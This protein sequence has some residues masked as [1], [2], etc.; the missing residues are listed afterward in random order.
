MRAC[1]LFAPITAVVFSALVGCDDSGLTAPGLGFMVIQTVTNGSALDPDGYM[2]VVSGEAASDTSRVGVIERLDAKNLAPGQYFIELQDLS[3]N[4]YSEGASELNLSVSAGETV[5]VDFLVRC[6]TPIS[7][8][9]VFWSDRGG[10]R[11]L[12]VIASDGTHERQLTDTSIWE[13]SPAVSPDGTR[14]AFIGRE[15]P[16]TDDPMDLYVIRADGTGRRNLTQNDHAERHPSWSPDGNH[17]VFTSHPR[18]FEPQ[19]IVVIGAD[20]SDL[21]VVTSADPGRDEDPVWSPNGD[22]ILFSRSTGTRQLFTIR[23]DGSD[24][25][26]ITTELGLKFEPAWSPSG[27]DIVYMGQPD[28]FYDIYIVTA[29]G[30]ASTRLTNRPG[31][32]AEPDFSPNGNGVVFVSERNGSGHLHIVD[33]DGSNPRQLTFGAWNNGSPYW[34]H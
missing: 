4:C 24:L 11:D 23:L 32:D 26:Q 27:T 22:L 8:E 25:T 16:T 17:I 1:L 18:T 19:S 7:D 13:F 30:G 12:Y 21:Q 33:T 6:F 29:N 34:A 10:N 14:I 5:A 9:I 15:G 31:L 20:G 3:A 28:D 2:I